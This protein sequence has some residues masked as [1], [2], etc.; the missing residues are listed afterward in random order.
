MLVEHT[1]VTTMDGPEALALARDFLLMGGFCVT[2][3]VDNILEARRGREK[4][5][6]AVGMLQLPQQVRMEF[7]RGRVNVAVQ[8]QLDKL[9]A[10]GIPLEEVYRLLHELE[11]QIATEFARRRRRW[12]IFAIVMLVIVFGSIGLLVTLAL[13]L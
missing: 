7:D 2:S 1:F 5:R 8:L 10:H 13:V 11:T 9:L 12:V 3:Q 4:S 6:Q